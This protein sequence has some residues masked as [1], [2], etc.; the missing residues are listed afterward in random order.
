MSVTLRDIAKHTGVSLGTVS[1]YLNGETV[2]EKTR[3]I[4]ERAVRELGYKEDLVSKAKR[5]GSSM[6]IAVIV[7]VM[8]AEFFIQILES[9]DA[10]LDKHQFSILLCSFHKDP[11]VLKQKLLDL[12]KRTIDGLILFP[13]GLEGDVVDLLQQY[14]DSEIPV[15]VIDDFVHGLETDAVIVDNKQA[16]FRATEHLILQNHRDIGFLVGRKNS[17]VAQNRYQGCKEAFETYDI[18]WNENY[19]RWTDFNIDKSRKMFNDLWDMD[20]SISAVFASSFDITMGLLLA[21]VNKNLSIPK[22]LS[23][24]GFDR[25]TGTDAFSPRLSLVEQPISKIG[26]TAAQLIIK[27]IN[28]NWDDYPEVIELK[29]KMLIRDSVNTLK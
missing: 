22:D 3:E 6:T 24:F 15:V 1:R 2:R 19:V 13:S 11:N 26:K 27:R 4:L 20:S 23:I 16:A 10:E 29:T 18:P 14:L 12:R 7:S 21:I 17:F 28:G 9:L 8:N 25:F 5:T